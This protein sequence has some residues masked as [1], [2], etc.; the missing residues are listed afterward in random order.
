MR[1]QLTPL[2]PLVL[3]SSS[4]GLLG[5]DAARG[6]CRALLDGTL[7][8]ADGGG[9]GDGRGAEVTSV[10][11]GDGVGDALVGPVLLSAAARGAVARG[12][13]W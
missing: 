1:Q 12:L 11:L 10:A 3:L 2:L 9:A 13:G 8:L 4:G 5:L 7:R 6:R